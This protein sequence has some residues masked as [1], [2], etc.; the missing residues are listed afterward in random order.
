MVLPFGLGADG[1]HTGGQTTIMVPTAPPAFLMPGQTNVSTVIPIIPSPYIDFI[2]VNGD[3]RYMIRCERKA[4]LENSVELAKLIH[5]GP[6]SGRKGDNHF[7]IS[8][9]DKND[10]ELVIRFLETKFVK[11]SDHLHILKILE[12]AARFNCPDLIIHCIRELD[13]LLS[14]IT[15]VDVFRALWYYQHLMPASQNQLDSVITSQDALLAKKQ[16]HKGRTDNQ[17]STANSHSNPF[18]AEEFCAALLSNTLQ[19][20][21]MQAESVLTE[22]QMTELRFEELETI[23][24]RDSL[25]LS[26]ELVLFRCL[27][28]WSIAE[29]RRKKLEPTAENRRRVLGPLCYAP[30]YLLMSSNEFRRACERVELLDPTEITLVD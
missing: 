22:Q 30:R 2:V 14:S 3:D 28:D 12:L 29:C 26:S 9:V 18:T 8:N 4:V 24:K 1:Q 23:V 13:L 11:Y 17:S 6:N 5:A 27:S 7:Q 10:F 21:D 16:K 15:V 20:I 19:L 25:Q